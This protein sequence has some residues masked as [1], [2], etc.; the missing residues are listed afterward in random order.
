VNTLPGHSV[1]LSVTKKDILNGQAMQADGSVTIGSVDSHDADPEEAARIS[2]ERFAQLLEV[3][4]EFPHLKV[5]FAVGGWENSQYFSKVVQDRQLR[6]K[7]ISSVVAVIDRLGLDGV[8]L[9][10]EYPVTGGANEGIPADK[11]NFVTLLKELR[12]VLVN[13]FFSFFH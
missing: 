13:F 5:M 2:Q 9:D 8:D 10:W 1:S 6:M 3:A 12:A 11:E 7:F 4:A